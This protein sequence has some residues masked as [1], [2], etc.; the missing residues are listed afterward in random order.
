LDSGILLVIAALVLFMANKKS[1]TPTVPTAP[2]TGGTGGTG[3]DGGTGG[4]TGP[5]TVQCAPDADAVWVAWTLMDNIHPGVEAW[6][7]DWLIASGPQYTVYGCHW[8]IYIQTEWVEAAMITET[9]IEVQWNATYGNWNAW[10]I[11]DDIGFY[12]EI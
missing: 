2:G 8:Y 4:T 9:Y 3:G 11:E 10:I 5:E 1:T 12:P 7:R 6:N